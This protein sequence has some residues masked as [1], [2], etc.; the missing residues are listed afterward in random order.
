MIS[1]NNLLFSSKSRGARAHKKF[2]VPRPI[3]KK[4][5]AIKLLRGCPFVE[6]K[7]RRFS[8]PLACLLREGQKKKEKKERFNEITEPKFH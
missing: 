3:N 4:Q 5:P 7:K 1:R 8:F 6:H 2:Q